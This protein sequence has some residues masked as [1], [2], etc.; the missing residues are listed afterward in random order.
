MVHTEFL[1]GN[2]RKRD[3]LEDRGV[4]GRTILIWIF[5]MYGGMDWIDEAQDRQVASSS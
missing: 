2:M 1:W 3:H 4:E 5:K